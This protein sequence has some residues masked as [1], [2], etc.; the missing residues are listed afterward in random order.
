MKDLEYL[1]YKFHYV[2]ERTKPRYIKLIKQML[3]SQLI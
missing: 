3:I 2:G 1:I